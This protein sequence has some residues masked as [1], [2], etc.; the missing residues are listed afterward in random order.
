MPLLPPG[1]HFVISLC[2][3][4]C[5]REQIDSIHGELVDVVRG[6]IREY[7][8]R[9][10]SGRFANTRVHIQRTAPLLEEDLSFQE[11]EHKTENLRGEPEPGGGDDQSLTPNSGTSPDAGPDQ[12]VG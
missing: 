10:E 6:L 7:E 3:V 4:V 2:D 9:T 12:I 1:Y 5:T 11:R 8:L